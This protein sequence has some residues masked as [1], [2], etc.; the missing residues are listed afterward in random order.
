[1]MDGGFFNIIKEADRKS[2]QVFGRSWYAKD[3]YHIYCRGDILENA[4]YRTFTIIPLISGN[5]TSWLG[6]DRNNVYQVDR[7]LDEQ[8]LKDWNIRL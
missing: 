5:D 3:R 4:D 2:I 8:T 7:I 1:M 6:K